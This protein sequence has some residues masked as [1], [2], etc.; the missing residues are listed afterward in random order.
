[1]VHT[2]SE[3]RSADYVPPVVLFSIVN[4]LGLLSVNGFMFYMIYM[5]KVS[6]RKSR[7]TLFNVC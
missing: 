2:Y 1:M 5:Q 6:A 4:L 3:Y 7:G